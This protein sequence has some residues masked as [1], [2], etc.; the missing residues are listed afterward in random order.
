MRGISQTLRHALRAPLNLLLPGL[1]LIF[2]HPYTFGNI[3]FRDDDPD[4]EGLVHDVVRAWEATTDCRDNPLFNDLLRTVNDPFTVIVV[5]KSDNPHQNWTDYN[6]PFSVVHWNPNLRR[7][8]ANEQ[9]DRD[10]TASLIHELAHAALNGVGERGSSSEHCKKPQAGGAPAGEG[11]QSGGLYIENM[12]FRSHKMTMR[13]NYGYCS[14]RDDVHQKCC[15]T[16]GPGC[17]DRCCAEGNECERKK[18]CRCKAN[19][20]ACTLQDANGLCCGPGT[21]CRAGFVDGVTGTVFPPFCCTTGALNCGFR[22]GGPGTPA[23]RECCAVGQ[24]CDP[25]GI[26]G[27]TN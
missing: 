27:C 13:V 9:V 16:G 8:Y 17:N 14:I 4:F 22:P 24:H 26:R 19:Y 6:G 20:S 11:E 18:G 5:V 2:C 7:R 21:D 15:S 1:L 25:S 3:V 23:T 12:Y 10:P